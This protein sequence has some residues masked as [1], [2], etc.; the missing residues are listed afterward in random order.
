M[1]RTVIIEDEK[2]ARKSLRAIIT[3]NISDV[4]ILGEADNVKDGIELINKHKPAVVLLDIQLKNALSFDLLKEVD[5]A[6]MAIIFT[7]A[8]SEY[9]INAI[10]YSALDYLLKPIDPEELIKAFD[11]ARTR[12]V[13]DLSLI[14]I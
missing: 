7:T 5:Y 14:H 1:L 3:K 8:Y 9:A 4:E 2:R 12:K 11:L 6:N 10:K 13:L